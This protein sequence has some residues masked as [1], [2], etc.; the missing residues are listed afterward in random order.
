MDDLNSV[1]IEGTVHGD[2]SLDRGAS[3][4]KIISRHNIEQEMVGETFDIMA[5]GKLAEMCLDKLNH[6]LG[7][8]IIGKLHGIAG[9]TM[10]VAD[11]VE[12]KPERI[13]YGTD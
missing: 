9:Q 4:F 6:G 11:H 3:W 13:E 2:V 8:R 10:I 5:S 1:L 12:I 7:L